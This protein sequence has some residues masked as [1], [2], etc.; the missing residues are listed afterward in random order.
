MRL[1]KLGSAF[2]F[3]FSADS[4]FG[5]L[6]LELTAFIALRSVG[7]VFF[8]CFKLMLLVLFRELMELT[9]VFGALAG[10]LLALLNW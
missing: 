1:P 6:S 3:M 5:F 2:D 7:R 4:D 10:S 9:E 8:G